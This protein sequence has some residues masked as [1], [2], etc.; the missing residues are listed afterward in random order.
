LW[1]VLPSLVRLGFREWLTDR[2]HL[3][4]EDPG[5]LLLHAIARHH[6]IDAADPVLLALAPPPAGEP[7]PDWARWWR[8]GLDRWLRR[9]ARRRLHDLAGRAGELTWDEWRVDIRYPA[10]DIGLRRHA[11]D[12]DPGWT[13][14]LGLSVRF[15]FGGAEDGL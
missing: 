10:A 11:L 3:L 9:T 12:R 1:L 2:P 5:S 4:A 15:H 13:D 14:W 6:R 7:L 8:H